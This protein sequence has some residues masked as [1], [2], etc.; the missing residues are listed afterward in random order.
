MK[1][2][3][4]SLGNVLKKYKRFS[5]DGQSIAQS[6]TTICYGDNTV[7]DCSLQQEEELQPILCEEVEIAVAALKKKKSAGVKNIPEELVQS[8]GEKMIDKRFINC[9][10]N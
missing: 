8:G 9:L 4:T 7:L 1:L 2:S 10:S 3:K 5:A 6:L